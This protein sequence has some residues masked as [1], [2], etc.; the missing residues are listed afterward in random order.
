MKCHGTDGCPRGEVY[1][2]TNLS[3]VN[4]NDL[5]FLTVS[6][7]KTAFSDAMRVGQ[8]RYSLLSTVILQISISCSTT[9]R[10]ATMTVWHEPR[11]S[12]HKIKN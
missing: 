8:P 7:S 10:K 11:Y 4:Q 3:V 2:R 6:I 1:R 9:T 5:R 12:T